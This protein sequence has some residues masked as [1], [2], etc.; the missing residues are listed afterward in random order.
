MSDPKAPYVRLTK[1]RS[2]LN[3]L[4]SLWLGKD[5]LLLVTSTFAVE[6]YRRWFFPDLQ[7]VVMR[8]TPVRLVWNCI[9]G[10]LALAL[11]TGAVAA[12]IGAGEASTRDDAVVAYV[13]AAMFGIIGIGFLVVALINSAMGP[14]CALYIQTP[15][16]FD[17]LPTP[18]RVP[19]VEKLIARLQ[20]LLLVAQSKQG[21][22]T[23]SLREIAAALD[24]PLP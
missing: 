8:R 1:S 9:L 20:P 4:G 6:R 2:G 22:Q 15:H 21:E 5:H 10:V 7:V 13:L 3:G 18:N 12:F 14:T 24:Q 17:R 16:G 19:A 11:L 23:G